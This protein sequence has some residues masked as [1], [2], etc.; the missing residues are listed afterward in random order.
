MF[1]TAIS[2]LQTALTNTGVAL[3]SF[4]IMAIKVLLLFCCICVSY[5]TSLKMR[6]FSSFQDHR[7]ER[8]LIVLQFERVYSGL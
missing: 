2:W 3:Y 5:E 8:T 4:V 6:I 7:I 1:Y